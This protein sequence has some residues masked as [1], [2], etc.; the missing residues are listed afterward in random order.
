MN[1][2]P[3]GASIAEASKALQSKLPSEG[4]GNPLVACRYIGSPMKYRE[5]EG[6]RRLFLILWRKSGRRSRMSARFASFFPLIG[7]MDRIVQEI[8]GHALDWDPEKNL[9]QIRIHPEAD[10]SFMETVAGLVELYA[11]AL[12]DRVAW[13]EMNARPPFQRH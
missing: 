7:K 13:S 3:Y 6:K 4:S 2:M 11:P 1:L 5:A 12:K 10:N 9:E 8:F